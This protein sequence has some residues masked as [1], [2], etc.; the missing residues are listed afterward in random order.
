MI[1]KKITLLL[2]IT[3]MF[4]GCH[5]DNKKVSMDQWKKEILEAER[6]FAAMAKAEG[7]PEAFLAYAADSAVLMRNNSLVIGRGQMTEYFEKQSKS[8]AEM[9]LSW[10]PD[11]IDVSSSGDM[12]YTYG[13]FTFTMTDSTGVKQEGKGI[14]H[15]VWKRQQDG[16]WKF[17]WD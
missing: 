17:V 14:F 13:K 9:S 4:V 2:L 5:K 10:E 12:G 15:T 8:S 11:F 1:A 3:G 16:S 7:I 6:A